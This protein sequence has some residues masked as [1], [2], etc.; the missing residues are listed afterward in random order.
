MDW[1]KLVQSV[2][3]LYSGQMIER[4]SESA[5]G[6]AVKSGIMAFGFISFTVFFLASILMVFIDLGHQFDAH[7]GVSLSGMM[8]SALYLFTLGLVV[9]GIC[10]GVTR[11][12]AAK[13]QERRELERLRQREY[14]SA[15]LLS[16]GEQILKQVIENLKK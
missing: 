12:L 16:L 8:L 14:P 5:K 11:I 2:I 1:L 7:Q 15:L 6:I 9:L 4:S 10:Y 13:E 3:Q